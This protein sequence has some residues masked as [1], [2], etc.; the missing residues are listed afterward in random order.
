[1]EL[2]PARDAAGLPLA[3]PTAVERPLEPMAFRHG[4][5]QRSIKYGYIAINTE[6]WTNVRLGGRQLGLTPLREIKLPVGQHRLTFE[7]PQSHLRITVRVDVQEGK[8]AHRF[9][10]KRSGSGWSVERHLT[11]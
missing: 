11:L 3:P 2:G 10:F 9:M 4:R 7:N 6:P 1:M 8:H 5:Q